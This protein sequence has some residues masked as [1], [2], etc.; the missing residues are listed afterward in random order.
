MDLD[1]REFFRKS[2]LYAAPLI[3]TASVRPML[4]GS[5]YSNETPP[6]QHDSSS[7]N[8]L[9]ELVEQVKEV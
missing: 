5:P 7:S 9:E 3:V 4:A 2:A 8:W 6:R 1:R